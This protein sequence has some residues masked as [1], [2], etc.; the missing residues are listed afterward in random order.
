MRLKEGS[1]DYRYFPDPDLGPIELS[2]NRIAK[3]MQELPELP[4]KKRHKYVN[5]FGLSAYDARI[6]SDEI[7]MAIFF[8]E[9]VKYGAD[10]KIASNWITSDISGYLKANKQ[11]FNSIT[12]TSKNLAEM[13]D[14]ISSN[15]ISGKIA[16]DI[17]PELIETNIPPKKLVDKKGLAMISDSSS[18]EIIVDAL[19]KDH[20]EEVKAYKNGKTKLLGF[21]VGQLM[22]KTKG[23]ADPKLANKIISS[24]LNS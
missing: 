15:T 17:L 13:I 10:P 21:F 24:K 22:K 6:L 8:E 1:S 14:L 16:K 4:Y 23:K 2:K 20:P 9:T 19:I 11:A 18:L 12:M 3:W 7:Y 5:E